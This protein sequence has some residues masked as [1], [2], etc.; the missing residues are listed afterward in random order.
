MLVHLKSTESLTAVM[1]GAASATNPTYLVSY[2]DDANPNQN[3]GQLNGVTAVSLVPAPTFARLVS[4]VRFYN[5]DSAA[6]TITLTKVSAGTNYTLVV[7]TLQAGGMAVI[8][9]RGITV[10]DSS[11]SLIQSQSSSSPVGAVVANVTAVEADGNPA[12]I[13]V[14]RTVLSLAGL[15]VT[16]GNTTGV[17]FGGS[18]IYDFPQ[19]RILLLSS[20]LTGVTFDLEDAGNVTPVDAADG[21]DISVGT[22]APS[23][24]TLTATDV[25]IIPSTSIDPISAG[26]ASAALAAA[27]VLDGSATPIDAY[28]NILIDDADV[29]DGAS[30]VLLVSAVLTLNWGII[31][32]Y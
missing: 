30:D 25:N 19:G 31:N 26:V 24:G 28:F 32:S 12:N 13:A 27:A 10:M 2:F 29:G 22:T 15:S 3:V 7:V 20:V 4:R 11:G 14:H 5:G 23:D 16:V 6:V 21:G 17:S 8:D 9:E 1:S 18:K